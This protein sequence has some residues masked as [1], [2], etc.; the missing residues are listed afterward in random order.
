MD[1]NTN[2]QP[3]LSFFN[4]F[5][6]SHYQQ[7]FSNQVPPPSSQNPQMEIRLINLER[8]MDSLIKTQESLTQAVI[9]LEIQLSQQANLLPSQPL[10]NPRYF[11]QANKAQRSTT[12]SM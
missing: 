7:N 8:R 2:E 9:R 3:R 5:H 12:K 10:P 4:N 6:L 11:G 1:K